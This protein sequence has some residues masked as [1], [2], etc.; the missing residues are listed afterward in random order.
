[1]FGFLI[2]DFGFTGAA[3]AQP[4]YMGLYWIT[5][6]VS[7]PDSVGTEGRQVCFY[8]TLENNA[9]V[10][11]YADDLC[12][13]V[14]LSGR[15]N[16]YMINAW[17]DFR[18]LIRPGTYYVAI[19]NDNPADPANGYGADP[20]EVTVTGQG[21]DIVSNNLVLMRGA[22]IAPP[23]DRPS[24]GMPH[25][26][27]IAFGNRKYQPALVARGQ[28]FIVSAQPRISGRAVSEYGLNTSS[29]AMVVG[30][31]T[32]NAKTYSI[33]GSYVTQTVG[34]ADSP[35]SVA[36]TVD[37]LSVGDTLPEGEQ[38][39]TFR[40]ANA[41]GS[42]EEVV[43]VTVAGGE[44]RLIGEPITFPSP[45]HLKTDREVTFQYVLSHDLNTEMFVF[46]VSG[47]IVLRRPFNAR[48]EGGSAG[49][50]KVTWN[51]YTDQ[52]SLVS[53]GIYV[54]T[55]VNRESGKLLGKGKF[56]ALP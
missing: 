15:A 24:F 7:D 56:T 47:R 23:G 41:F 11:G 22:G 1:M 40:A 25:F 27:D 45:L 49:F 43:A 50:N 52:G 38:K 26:E 36:F 30:E 46:D 34:A 35:T 37:F 4:V 12:G 20:V 29:I 18:L 21:Y 10:G 55:L 39:I 6:S 16:Q 44:P 5:G 19:P 8:E 42:T 28:E 54:F 51:L 9:I 17:E 13:T 3:S 31:G 53:S 33:A 14:G 48:Q 2:S 32:T